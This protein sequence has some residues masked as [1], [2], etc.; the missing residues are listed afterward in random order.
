MEFQSCAVHQQMYGSDT[1]AGPRTWRLQ[2]PCP[3]AQSGVVRNRKVEA[4]QAG[5]GADKAFGLPKRQAEHSPKGQPRQDRQGRI[6]WLSAAGGAC[7]GLPSRD[8]LVGEPDRQAA[9]LAQARV[10]RSPVRNLALL[11]GDNEP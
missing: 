10:I 11:P 2:R 4:E 9:A 1:G 5:D 8:R 6:I 7:F 3:T